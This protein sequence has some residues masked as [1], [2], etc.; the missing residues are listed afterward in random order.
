MPLIQHDNSIKTS[1][2]RAFY[3]RT[4]SPSTS[5][6]RGLTTC[7]LFN[8]VG[9]NF[10]IDSS[11]FHHNSNPVQNATS[12][13]WLVGPDP[14]DSPSLFLFSSAAQRVDCGHIPYLGGSKAATIITTLRRRADSDNVSVGRGGFNLDVLSDGNVYMNMDG[15]YGRFADTTQSDAWKQIAFTFD[16]TQA[17]NIDRLKGY[18][19]GYRQTLTFNGSIPFIINND[20]FNYFY[21]NYSTE[22]GIYTNGYYK[23]MAVW[24]RVLSDDEIRMVYADKEFSWLYAPKY[25]YRAANLAPLADSIIPPGE[26]QDFSLKIMKRCDMSLN[27]A[28]SNIFEL[29]VR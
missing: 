11:P 18:E 15:I 7:Y 28:K 19:N 12:N 2:R 29:E 21:I 3:S 27:L 9:C 14:T 10:L 26:T 13:Y 16:G 17:N 6:A 1:G 8:H 20:E 23:F 25:I 5:L 22:L 4:I 24:N